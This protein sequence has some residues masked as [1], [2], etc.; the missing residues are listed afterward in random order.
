MGDTFLVL[1]VGLL[2]CICFEDTFVEAEVRW[3]RFGEGD[4]LGEP[5]LG[6]QALDSLAEL[7]DLCGLE[8]RD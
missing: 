5:A 1:R 4:T 3:E 2:G 8:L 6:S 7:G